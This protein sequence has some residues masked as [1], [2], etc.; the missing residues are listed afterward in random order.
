MDHD[1]NVKAKTTKLLKQYIGLNLHDL[2]LGSDIS[3]YNLT[4]LA[5]KEKD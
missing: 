2:R 3:K 1:L 5:T 4:A